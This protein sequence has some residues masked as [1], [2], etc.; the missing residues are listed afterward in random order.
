MSAKASTD[1]KKKDSEALE[2]Q[3]RAEVFEQIMKQYEL[4]EEQ[5]K[6][7]VTKKLKELARK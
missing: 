6:A 4:D 3:A 2:E 1:L 7:E 5:K